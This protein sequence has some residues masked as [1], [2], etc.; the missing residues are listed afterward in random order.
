MKILTS[1]QMKEIDRRTI[2]DIGIPGPVLMENAGIQIFRFLQ[3]VILPKLGI[4][5]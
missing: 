1:A 4:S 3:T 2:Q 5:T